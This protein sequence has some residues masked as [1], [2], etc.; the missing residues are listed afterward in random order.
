MGPNLLRPMSSIYIY[1]ELLLNIRQITVFVLLPS[2]CDGT[3][4]VWLENDQKTLRLKHK[5]EEAV[6]E[7]PCSVINNAN[8]KITP[9]TTRELSFRFAV[10]GAAKTPN[11]V[12]QSAGCNDPWTASTLTSETQVACGSCGTLLVNNVNV[13]KHLPSA[14]WADMMDFWHCHKPSASNGD[15]E[16]V[17]STKGYAAANAL[18]PRAGI[19][20]VD[21]S[22]LLV[23]NID[24]TGIEVGQYLLSFLQMAMKGQQEGGLH[25]KTRFHGKVAD[26]IAP[27]EA[28]ASK[29]IRAL[30]YPL[31]P[32]CK[33]GLSHF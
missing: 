3:T 25:P 2:Y 5:D 8:L 26:T 21:V 7:L 18:G 6:I 17:G 28:R 31:H 27:E 22:Q 33:M 13:W 19:G 29:S 30:S 16:Y 1:A 15:D 23:S 4:L 32:W 9:A 14:G 10:D 24:C 11:Q 20:L 12:R